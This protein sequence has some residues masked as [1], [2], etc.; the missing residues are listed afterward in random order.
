[1]PFG[2]YDGL[3]GDDAASDEWDDGRPA[4]AQ[5]KNLVLVVHADVDCFY[6]QCEQID[7]HLDDDRQPIGIG[8]KHI[9]VT[10]NYAA[11][12]YGVSKLMLQSDAI[13]KCP[14]LLIFDGSDLERY[15]QHSRRIYECFR[16]ACRELFTNQASYLNLSIRKGCMD[17]MIAAIEIVDTTAAAATAAALLPAAPPS[18]KEEE[19]DIYVHGDHYQQLNDPSIRIGTHEDPTTAGDEEEEERIETRRRRL[20]SKDDDPFV[21]SMM[22]RRRLLFYV[23]SVV[24]TVRQRIQ[25]ETGFAVTM[26]ISTNPFLAKLASGLRKPGIVNLLL[27]PNDDDG[28]VDHFYCRRAATTSTTRSLVAGL[29]LR[30]VTGVGRQTVRALEPYLRAQRLDDDRTA[31][32]D[33]DHGWTC[34]YVCTYL[35]FVCLYQHAHMHGLWSNWNHLLI[36]SQQQQGRVETAPGQRHFGVGECTIQPFSVVRFLSLLFIF[37]LRLSTSQSTHIYMSVD[38]P[39]IGC[40]IYAV[41]S[42][43]PWSWT[44]RAVHPKHCRLKIPFG[45]A[46]RRQ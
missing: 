8:Q 39:A 37:F 46:R 12:E 28:G 3:S 19:R 26:G 24:R 16:T 44:T 10:C 35:V 23:A 7:R 5:K 40:S 36:P 11:R 30:R 6:C 34:G 15:R 29:P 20:G 32:S 22:R 41:V 18:E 42:I 9:I 43:I 45:V 2:Y 4:P 27:P 33:D 1:M 38:E 13:Q 25:D 14:H 31:A 17:E 21:V